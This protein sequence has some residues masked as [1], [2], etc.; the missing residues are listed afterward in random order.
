MSRGQPRPLKR[1][2]PRRW[3]IPQT[4][5]RTVAMMVIQ[6]V[7]FRINVGK[8]Q[9]KFWETKASLPRKTFERCS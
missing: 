8:G 6:L 5:P 1:A 4:C 9:E 2:F 3:N 7:A